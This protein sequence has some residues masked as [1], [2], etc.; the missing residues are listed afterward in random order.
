MMMEGET[1]GR[2]LLLIVIS[3]T[4]IIVILHWPSCR[5][6][7]LIAQQPQHWPLSPWTT[8]TSKP[9]PQHWPFPFRSPTNSNV[10]NSTFHPNNKTRYV[11]N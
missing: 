1:T 8:P 10:G 9:R 5:Q 3:N 4:I 11:R 7:C 6:P 2:V